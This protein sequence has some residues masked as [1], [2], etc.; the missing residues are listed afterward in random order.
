MLVVHPVHE[1]IGQL[2]LLI[3]SVV[4]GTATGSPMWSVG[5]LVLM[6]AYGVARWY[7]TA[8][9][10]DAEQVQ[11]RTG[12]LQRKVLSLPRNRI[13]SVSTDAR[14]L[15][16]LLGLTVVTIGT[17]QEGRGDA[18]FS[19]DAVTLDE[20]APLRAL[21]VGDVPADVDA[22]PNDEVLARWQPAW[23]RYSPLTFTG[24]ATIA[25]A[26]A[27]VYQTGA[28]AALRDSP[29]ARAG[30]DAAQRA[31][32]VVT[33][34]VA[35]AAV[36]IGAA[37]LSLTRSLFTYGNLVLARRDDG[38]DGVLHLEHGLLRRREH[39]Y[40]VARLRGATLR[41]PA[42]IRVFGGARLDAVM[43]GVNGAGEA[44][45][46]LPACPRA[47]A[48][49]VLVA[50]T[51]PDVLAEL[52][53]HGPAAMRRRWTKAFTV[54]ALLAVV[55]ACLTVSTGLSLWVWVAF[56]LFCAVSAALAADR[57]RALGH[58]VDARWL[59]ARAGSLDRRRDCISAEGVIGWT[60][61]QTLFQ[62]RAGLATLV[63]ATAAG[64]KGYRVLD[65]PVDV[66]WAVAAAASPWVATSEW[67][68]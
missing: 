10:I 2:P 8:Y 61:R 63:A 11:L 28:V 58:R 38:G 59:V 21:L 56:L 54:P 29:L 52:R 3:G 33:I 17:G 50:L 48:T 43:T 60:V 5:V 40:D 41:E 22:P 64:V 67:A 68:V 24:L 47:T 46:L 12:V 4:L 31:G 9:R 32:I 27:V 37:L 13:R 30:L 34:I 15:H 16:R 23:L 19:L 6:L 57:C 65:V 1:V 25:A 20:L 44:S 55:L 26:L 45:L 7:V 14:V 18:E 36:V 39:T 51:T 62:R 53:P 66:A 42:L 35:V 49:E